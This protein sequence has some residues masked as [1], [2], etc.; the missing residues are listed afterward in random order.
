MALSTVIEWSVCVI[1]VSSPCDDVARCHSELCV[2]HSSESV[3][4]HPIAYFRVWVSFCGYYTTVMPGCCVLAI[5]TME[6]CTLSTID[7]FGRYV[8]WPAWS[9]ASQQEY[10]C[11]FRVGIVCN[12][13]HFGLEFPLVTSNISPCKHTHTDGINIITQRLVCLSLACLLKWA[14]TRVSNPLNHWK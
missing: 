13:A 7:H 6:S 3:F 9:F 11:S 1:T 12:T 4:I 10:L 5:C 14:R 8:R 2:C